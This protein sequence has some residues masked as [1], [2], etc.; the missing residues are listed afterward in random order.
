MSSI[1]S[2]AWLNLAAT[3]SKD[4]SGGLYFPRNPALSSP[5]KV[6]SS[7][8]TVYMVTDSSAWQ[9]H[10]ESSPLNQRAW[11]QQERFLAPRVVHFSY[12]QTWWQCTKVRASEAFPTEMPPYLITKDDNVDLLSLPSPTEDPTANDLHATWLRWVEGYSKTDITKDSDRLVATAGIANSFLD[13]LHPHRSLYLAGIMSEHLH[14][15]LLWRCTGNSTKLHSS[16]APS[17]SWASVKGQI[18][19]DCGNLETTHPILAP[20]W[21]TDSVREDNAYPTAITYDAEPRTRPRNIS[22]HS[23]ISI[24][25]HYNPSPHSVIDPS[26][27]KFIRIR[28]PL[29][30]LQ[31][32]SPGPSQRDNRVQFQKG[33]IAAYEFWPA[34]DTNYLDEDSWYRDPNWINRKTYFCRF[35]PKLYPPTVAAEAGPNGYGHSHPDGLDRFKPTGLILE[36]TGQRGEYRRIGWMQAHTDDVRSRLDEEEY[37]EDMNDGTYL[38]DIV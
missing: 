24:L 28:A 25:K 30:R 21:Y 33:Q 10:I 14:I 15:S 1:Y 9:R 35:L 22:D 4:G 20:A 11:V 29:C 8:D 32:S 26:Q 36:P 34:L 7:D 13:L 27:R 17:W 31:M 5:L 18:K 3:S 6:Q 23:A 2:H 19:F 38:I 37:L 16:I 12:D